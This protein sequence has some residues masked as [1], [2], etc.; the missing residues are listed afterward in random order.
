VYRHTQ[1][2]TLVDQ[3]GQPRHVWTATSIPPS[4]VQADIA[5][6]GPGSLCAFRSIT[7]RQGTSQVRGYLGYAW[8]ADS[9]GEIGCAGGQGQFD[10]LANLSTSD[11]PQSGYVTGACGLPDGAQ[12][13][14]NL[15]GHGAPN[16]YLD[17]AAG[18]VR[19]VSLD[20]PGFAHPSEK[21]AWGKLNLQSTGLLLHPTG[22]LVSINNANHKIEV[23]RL[24]RAPMSDDD[25]RVHLL[26]DVRSGKGSRPG[27][28]HGPSAAAVSPDG[29][30]LILEDQHRIQ[31][32]DT[33]GGPVP[34]FKKR[35]KTPYW[36]ELTATEAEDTQYVDL[37]VEFT[38]YLYVLSFNRRTNEYRMDLYHPSQSDT[39]PISTT[40]GVNAA[41]LTVDFWRNVYTLNYEVLQV[42]PGLQALTEP[43]VSLWTPSPP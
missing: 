42:P 30:I 11:D 38:G 17:S 20:P 3:G 14:Y 4:T 27:L 35:T 43:S 34:F 37:A 1:K 7:V 13:A 25:A 36:L 6:E 41:R 18:I 21:H 33:G 26:A 5:C 16:F 9:P 2:T 28:L 10:L 29:V 32:F 39:T 22:K 15:M 19:S 12:V 31:A 23:L 8:K 24:P 40:R